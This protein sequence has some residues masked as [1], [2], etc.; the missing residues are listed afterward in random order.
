MNRFLLFQRFGVFLFAAFL[1]GGPPQLR[2]QASAPPSAPAASVR[3]PLTYVNSQ[4]QEAQL[5]LNA[6]GSFVLQEAGQTYHG[7]FSINGQTLALRISDTSTSTA[8]IQGSNLVDSSGQTWV[9]RA[10]TAH[11]VAARDVLRNQ[12]VI[13]LAQAG[14]DDEIVVA[15]IGKSEC[16]FDTSAGALAQAKA[17]G[18]S[19]AA[20]KAMIAC[21]TPPAAA[22]GDGSAL[23]SGIPEVRTSVAVTPQQRPHHGPDTASANSE[24]ANSL[25]GAS[26]VP[27]QP[28]EGLLHNEDVIKMV[29]AGFDDALI[30]DKVGSSKCQF[31]TSADALIQLKQGGA[32]GPVVRA[33]MEASA[34][35]GLALTGRVVWNGVPVPNAKVRLAHRDSVSAPASART[36][37]ANDGAFTIQD[38]PAGDLMI[39]V[40]APSS[41][42]TDLAGRAVTITAGHPE[43][44]GSVSITKKLQLL[45]PTVSE[46]AT[47]TPALE[48]APFP[49]SVRYN[50]YVFNDSTR[51]RILLRSTKDTRMTV[52]APL[53]NGQQLRWGVQAYNSKGEEIAVSW[54]RFTIAS[55]RPNGMK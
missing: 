18:V 9:Q 16:R 48:W 38:P 22:G 47:T 50:V 21:S 36:V 12:D 1:S 13:A 53:P 31:D 39:W 2:G 19:A 20:V 14:L 25:R 17:A 4:A 29:K 27:G 32:S 55:G 5:Q 24:P 46:I 41:E 23:P 45:S 44:I 51:Q 43:N 15:K 8:T 6:D 35:R 30:I 34:P 28:A 42:Y 3:L 26:L 11:A 37:T 10:Q 54:W 40:Y 7:T 52:P 49:D 33:V